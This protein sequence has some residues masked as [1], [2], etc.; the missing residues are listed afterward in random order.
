MPYEEALAERIRDLLAA[1]AELTE[2]KMFGGLAFL[3]EGRMALAVSGQGG[4]MVRVGADRADQL[5]ATTKAE[6]MEMKGR[7]MHGWLRVGTEHLR[8]KRQLER[9]VTLGAEQA[10]AAR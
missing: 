9:W 10:R 2:K 3:L 5:V 1:E 6:P 8:T 7:T 4:I